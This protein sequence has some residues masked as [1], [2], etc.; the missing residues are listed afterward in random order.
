MIILHLAGGI[1]L[2]SARNQSEIVAGHL[3]GSRAAGATTPITS[4][5]RGSPPDGGSGPPGLTVLTGYFESGM[6][7]VVDRLTEGGYPDIWRGEKG[8]VRASRSGH[9]HQPEELEIESVD[10][11]E[12][13]SDPDDQGMVLA[14][15]CPSDGCSGTYIV[16]HGAIMPAMD[17]GLIILIPDARRL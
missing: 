15:R 5:P 17:G 8:G 14:V 16:P 10:R 4:R 3:T 1:R 12:G 9:L 7:A 13:I 6:S 2:N 11:F